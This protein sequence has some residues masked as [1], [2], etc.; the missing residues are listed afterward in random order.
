MLSKTLA[1]IEVCSVPQ[2]NFRST[3]W[4]TTGDMLA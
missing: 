1:D 2:K 4:L 3:D